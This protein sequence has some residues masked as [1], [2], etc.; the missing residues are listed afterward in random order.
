FQGKELFQKFGLPVAERVLIN[1]VGRAQEL[2]ERIKSDELVVKVQ[3]PFGKR[4]KTGGIKFCKKS[5][6]KQ[7]IKEFLGKEFQGFKVQEVLVEPK[8]EIAKEF[9]LALAVDR[10]EKNF[11]LIF[12]EE[13][14]VDIEE[15]SDKSPQKIKK[16]NFLN[17]E[18]K[19]L[20]KFFASNEKSKELQDLSGK[21]F[22]LMKE[23][24][25]EL[26][27]I[28]PL[29]VDVK[30]K[31]LA[32]DAKITIDDNALFRHPEFQQGRQQALTEIEKK[33]QE[34]GLQYVELS[35][36]IAV[37]GNGAG[38]VMSTLDLLNFFGGKP[39]NFLDIGG[40]ATKEKMSRASEIVLMKPVK[41]FLINIFGGITRCDEIALG[42]VKYKNLHGVKVPI[43]VRMIGTN[44]VEGKKILERAGIFCEDSME[45]A[46]KKVVALAK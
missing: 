22:K 27:E 1:D 19:E 36:N 18:G 4:G 26:V 8:A 14:G 17:L 16:L 46:I 3:I 32:L 44:E 37:V 20:K 15:L 23:T 29:I 45:A 9:Y 38:L 43:V 21:L 7:T 28:N 25:A 33:A 41:A 40:G 11:V 13:G 24:D 30:G 42:I 10:T 5:E 12:S 34:F 31:L 39:A 6:L 35:G 2:V